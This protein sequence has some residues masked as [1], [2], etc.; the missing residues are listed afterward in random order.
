M[1]P[2]SRKLFQS[3]EDAVD[4]LSSETELASDVELD[5]EDSLDPEDSDEAEESA[6]AD[7]L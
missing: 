4:F 5:T 6:L 1:P 7:F 2:G 3:P